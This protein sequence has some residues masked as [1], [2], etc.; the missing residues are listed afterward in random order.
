M[1]ISRIASTYP[2]RKYFSVLTI[3]PLVSFIVHSQTIPSHAT[4][5]EIDHWLRSGDPRMVAW[6]AYFA[7]KSS[8]NDEVPVLAA[9]AENYLPVPPQQYDGHGNYIPRTTE[10]KDR[11][12]SMQAVL[13]SVIQLH[14]TLSYEAIL[15]VMSDFPDQALTLFAAMRE[16][17]RSEHAAALY[18]TRDESDKSYDWHQLG[19]QQMIHMAAAIL[20]LNPPPGF[21]ATLLNETTVT[22]KI[23]VTD[24]DQKGEGTFTG[25]MCG[26]SFGLVPAPG[27]PQPYTYV[28]E[29]HWRTQ[30]PA[31]GVL[32]P[33]EPAI[34]MRRARSNSS[35]SALSGF[36]SVQK[37][38]LAQQLADVSPGNLGT[39]TLQ[40]DTLRYPGPV[41][42]LS[43]LVVLI[44]QH[45]EPFQKLAATLAAKSFLTSSEAAT[46]LPAFAVEIE[47]QRKDKSEDLS[48]PQFLGPRTTVDPYK[49]ETGWFLKQ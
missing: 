41:S 49:P 13:D 4:S 14:G 7:A 24:D 31:E 10:Q 36:T 18:A 40:Y 29:Q 26:D 6:G 5:D 47:D 25:G 34:T 27:W 30:G 45:K 39:G 23:S 42:F 2:L 15:A 48:V 19:R 37:L 28:V 20:A 9:L 43:S 33:G 12:D 44:T 46:V 8:D 22:L 17:E 16:P 32:I 1:R 3:L 21:A 11:L 35:C 38:L